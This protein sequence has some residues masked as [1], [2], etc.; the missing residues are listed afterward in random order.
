MSKGLIYKIWANKNKKYLKIKRAKYFQKY[1]QKS[2][3]NHKRYI[4]KNPWL[5][6]LYNAR[7]RCVNKND[8]RYKWYG[9]RGIQCLLTVSQI[10]K[11]WFRDK[12]YLMKKPSIDR[13]N[14]KKNYECS[15][16]QFIE[17]RLNSI[18]DRY[19]SLY[20]I[21][22]NKIIKTWKSLTHLQKETSW[23]ISN[24]HDAIRMG[25]IS[26]GTYWKR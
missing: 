13:I 6:A 16:C 5:P 20:Q 15:N 7:K 1:K 26:H 3:L 22:N 23:D 19:K 21:K 4:Q 24:I 11:L 18:K 14:V 9:G 8:K 25:R 10:K 12:A 17:F 2:Y